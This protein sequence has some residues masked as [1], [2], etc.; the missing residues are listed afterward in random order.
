MGKAY[1]LARHTT[2]LAGERARNQILQKSKPKVNGISNDE[3]AHS[4]RSRKI[5]QLDHPPSR[6]DEKTD[7]VVSDHFAPTSKSDYGRNYLPRVTKPLTRSSRQTQTHTDQ[8]EDYEDVVYSVPNSIE[9]R[10]QGSAWRKP[11]IYPPNGRRLATVA[12]DDLERLEDG[13]MLNDS[14]V[15][16]FLRYLQENADQDQVKTMHFFSTFFYEVLMRRSEEKGSKGQINYNGVA[17][18]TKNIFLFRRDFVIVPVHELNHWYAMVVC[19]L[20]SLKSRSSPSVE[21]NDDVVDITGLDGEPT[22]PGEFP[23]IILE[24]D[25]VVPNNTEAMNTSEVEE[26]ENPGKKRTG[27]RRSIHRG[28]RKYDLDKP[29]IITLDSL[30]ISRSATASA[31]KDYLVQEAREKSQLEIEKGNI[32][33]MT[34]KSIPLQGNY[35]DCG[36]YL[37]AYLEQFMHDPHNFV[38]SI[39]QRDADALRWP[40][41]LQSK[42]LRQR[43]YELLQELHLAQEQKRDAKLPE[44]GKILIRDEDFLAPERKSRVEKTFSEE[45]QNVKAGLR[46]VDAYYSQDRGQNNRSVQA[47]DNKEPS[48]PIEELPG[49]DDEAAAGGFTSADQYLQ[50]A[51]GLIVID[52]DSQPQAPDQDGPKSR[53]FHQNHASQR[54][55]SPKQIHD[56]PMELVDLMRRNSKQHQSLSTEE[57]ST[58]PSIDLVTPIE[59]QPQHQRRTSVSTDFLTGDDSYDIQADSKDVDQIEKNAFYDFNNESDTGIHRQPRDGSVIPES[60]Y[61][62]SRNDAETMIID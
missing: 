11:L 37:C 36:L 31:L 49:H 50:Q 20:Q 12:W 4:K 9:R 56:T 43:L 24:S 29:V 7:I 60:D 45:Q 62:D 22:I 57:P 14:L 61:G 52:D 41:R 32:L 28:R 5:D 38:K 55:H 16:L 35:Y 19:N 46:F 27:R 2:V 33:G 51:Q 3:P 59:D 39:L 47:E 40:A 1:A 10:R 17:N 58:N 48:P 23:K 34:A 30:D 8:Q 26:T 54:S 42:K 18:W 25:V 13:E 21:E 15:T 53:Y 6:T 44:V